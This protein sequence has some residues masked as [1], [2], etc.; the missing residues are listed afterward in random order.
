[1]QLFTGTSSSMCDMEQP[2]RYIKGEEARDTEVLII[3]D[4]LG[5][6]EN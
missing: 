4:H 2:P 6:I 5:K 1:M 3:C